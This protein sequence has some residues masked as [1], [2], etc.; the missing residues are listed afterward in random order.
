MAGCHINWLVVVAVTRA[1]TLL[2]SSGSADQSWVVSA[3][4]DFARLRQTSWLRI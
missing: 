2:D 4:P 1:V 3:G